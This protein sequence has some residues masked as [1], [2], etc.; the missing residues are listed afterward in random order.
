MQGEVGGGQGRHEVSVA[1]VSA[2]THHVGPE[3]S[4]GCLVEVEALQRIHN[5][6]GR[7]EKV[8]RMAA[9]EFW[10]YLLWYCLCLLLF[11]CV[12]GEV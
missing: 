4:S 10:R 6:K 8:V 5:P 12:D 2:T 7:Q 9:V 3:A 11:G 1:V